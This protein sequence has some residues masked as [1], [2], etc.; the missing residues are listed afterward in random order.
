MEEVIKTE[1]T[2]EEL[3][4]MYGEEFEIPEEVPVKPETHEENENDKAD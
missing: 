1:L 2:K 4:E 3:L